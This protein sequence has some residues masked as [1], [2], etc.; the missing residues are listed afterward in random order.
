MHECI[1]KLAF[2]ADDKFLCGI[3][4]SKMFCI[5]SVKDGNPIH[6]KFFE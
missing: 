6:T 5:W 3:S 2:S 1:N 4:A